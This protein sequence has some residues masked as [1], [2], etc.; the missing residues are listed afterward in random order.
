MIKSLTCS[1][2]AESG[3][4]AMKLEIFNHIYH[5]LELFPTLNFFD[6]VPFETLTSFMKRR[7]VELL[8]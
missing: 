2:S 1:R 6:S 4:F 7:T 5:E 8:G 3:L